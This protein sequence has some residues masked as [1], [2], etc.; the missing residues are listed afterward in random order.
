MLLDEGGTVGN[1]FDEFQILGRQFCSLLC[2]EQVFHLVDIVNQ[3]RLILCSYGNNVVHGQISEHTGFNLYFL[4]I[5]FPFH[6][7]AGFQFLLRHDAD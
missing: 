7:V 5:H 6:L 2:G 4:G 3:I 1:L